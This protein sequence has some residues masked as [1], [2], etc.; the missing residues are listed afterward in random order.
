LTGDP[1]AQHD[2]SMRRLLLLL[3][4]KALLLLAAAVAAGVVPA[5]HHRNA[6]KAAVLA[7]YALPDGTLPVICGGRA[8]HGSDLER[9][10]DCV[11][12]ATPAPA[13]ARGL[14]LRPALPGRATWPKDAT[15]PEGVNIPTPSARAPPAAFA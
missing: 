3:R 9:C 13:A 12:V 7:S 2:S 1:R 14:P 10:H 11:M 4:P 6:P 15:A 8:D 5:L